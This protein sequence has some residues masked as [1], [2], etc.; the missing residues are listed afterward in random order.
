M[1]LML[2]SAHAGPA[3]IATGLGALVA[4]TNLAEPIAYRRWWWRGGTRVCRYT[5]HRNYPYYAYYGQFSGSGSPIG[6]IL[7]IRH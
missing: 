5:R 6:P 1:A 4:E 2:S 3:S 7:D